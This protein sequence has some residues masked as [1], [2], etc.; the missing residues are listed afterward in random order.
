ML[1]K[2][3]AAGKIQRCWRIALLRRQR[4]DQLQQ[5]LAVNDDVHHPSGQSLRARK[6][7]TRENLVEDDDLLEQACLEAEKERQEMQN[8]IEP[9]IALISRLQAKQKV[10]CS[11]PHGNGF[12]PA[13]VLRLP[14]AP[15]C[16]TMCKA[17]IYDKLV[18]LGR[19]HCGMALCA[20]C[21]SRYKD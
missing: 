14:D 2:S 7:A 13:H 1:R 20:V 16:C 12:A 3:S 19:R 6:Q 10:P 5:V 9:T 17:T 21:I 11:C 18:L 15:S 4:Q 8:K